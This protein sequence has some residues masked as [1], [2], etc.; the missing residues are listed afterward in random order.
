MEE[1]GEPSHMS[2]LDWRWDKRGKGRGG[3]R[4]T[5]IESRHG[6]RDNEGEQERVNEGMAERKIDGWLVLAGW[7]PPPTH[8]SRRQRP[9]GAST[10]AAEER[11]EQMADGGED[12]DKNLRR[13]AQIG[14]GIG[15]W[16]AIM[17]KIKQELRGKGFILPWEKVWL[18]G[19]ILFV[20][21][22]KIFFWHF[23]FIW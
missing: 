22:L 17:V 21:Y 20:Y 8:L 23:Y 6:G 19:K 9:P 12:I 18:Y 16:F 1:K 7:F 15:R 4:Q 14:E 10:C 13:V 3:D 11:N 5:E 2:S